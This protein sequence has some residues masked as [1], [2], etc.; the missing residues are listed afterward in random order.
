MLNLF[1]ITCLSEDI[2]NINTF[3]FKLKWIFIWNSFEWIFVL[4][5]SFSLYSTDSMNK[6]VLQRRLWPMSFKSEQVATDCALHD[7]RLYWLFQH[8]FTQR[9]RGLHLIKRKVDFADFFMN[10]RIQFWSY[11]LVNAY[12]MH[13]PKS[14]DDCIEYSLNCMSS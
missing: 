9:E 3:D 12:A 14:L 13:I 2:R 5:D 11:L 6:R 8:S 7:G 1:P 4:Q 10:E